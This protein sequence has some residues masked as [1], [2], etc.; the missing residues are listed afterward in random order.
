MRDSPQQPDILTIAFE[1]A[2]SIKKKNEKILMAKT[3]VIGVGIGLQVDTVVLIVLVK[4]I[5]ENPQN[6]DEIIPSEIDGLP[7]T[8]REIGNIKAL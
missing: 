3:N 1:K 5:I 4:K 8:V 2:R 7:V 6:E